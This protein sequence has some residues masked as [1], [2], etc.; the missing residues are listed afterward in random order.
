MDQFLRTEM[1]KNALERWR[2]GLQ[3]KQLLPETLGFLVVLIPVAA[4]IDVSL[5]PE[6]QYLCN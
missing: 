6:S 5:V 4:L 3:E 1:S 2:I